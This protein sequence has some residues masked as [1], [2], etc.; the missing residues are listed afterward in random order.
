MICLYYLCNARICKLTLL[1]HR[2]SPLQRL[3]QGKTQAQH[4]QQG[5]QGL[6]DLG[7]SFPAP[8]SPDL[9]LPLWTLPLGPPPPSSTLWPLTLWP[10]PLDTLPP[11]STLWFLL[12]L[13]LFFFYLPPPPSLHLATCLLFP[14]SLETPSHASASFDSP[15]P[16]ELALG[17][18]FSW[19]PLFS[20]FTNV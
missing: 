4:L 10:L 15:F 16:W 14:F 12:S 5:F 6:R 2:Y 9:P 13:H 18:K 11:S 1:F 7:F 19:A 20:V 3:F 8:P 17:P